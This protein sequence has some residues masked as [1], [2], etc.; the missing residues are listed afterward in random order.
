M[1]VSVWHLDLFSLN[2]P[3]L[4]IAPAAHVAPVENAMV[5]VPL[6]L[7]ASTV[8][9]RTAIGTPSRVIDNLAVEAEPTSHYSSNHNLAGL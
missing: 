1:Q 4:T 7:T 6:A 3:M 5:L 9:E 8:V 2:A